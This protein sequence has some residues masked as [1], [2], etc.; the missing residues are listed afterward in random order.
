MGLQLR[1]SS[2]GRWRLAG[3]L[4][5]LIG[6]GGIAVTLARG[7]DLAAPLG[8]AAVVIMALGWA[9]LSV[10]IIRTRR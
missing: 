9:T 7:Q 3:L 10:A 4:L 8:T 5:V 6:G 2:S 1:S